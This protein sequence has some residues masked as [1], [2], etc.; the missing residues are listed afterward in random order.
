MG[1]NLS[2]LVT[3]DCQ[4]LVQT[5]RIW[6]MRDPYFHP[7][8]TYWCLVGNGREWG[9]LGLLLIVSKWI[10]PENS[11]LS[12]GKSN[13][14]SDLIHIFVDSRELPVCGTICRYL[15]PPEG[16]GCGKH[17]SAREMGKF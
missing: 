9:L 7:C 13:A 8:S 3:T 12:T 14:F 1:I 16:A 4:G 17:V 5:I 2:L 10:I 6:N 15:D 11:L